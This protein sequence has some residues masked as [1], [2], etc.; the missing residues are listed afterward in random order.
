MWVM[1]GMNDKT[2]EVMR[3]ITHCHSQGTLSGHFQSRVA[4]AI[5]TRAR[6]GRD[7]IWSGVWQ[8]RE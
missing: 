4:R 8:S 5:V 2:F 1:R 3:E 7:D 6:G